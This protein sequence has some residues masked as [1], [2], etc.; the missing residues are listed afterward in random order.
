[1]TVNLSVTDL[2]G[3]FTKINADR[4]LSGHHRGH[5]EGSFFDAVAG[6]LAWPLGRDCEIPKFLTLLRR[7]YSCY[8]LVQ[9]TL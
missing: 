6:G 7:A 3:Q 2:A 5:P 4:E 9:R 8:L 1:V